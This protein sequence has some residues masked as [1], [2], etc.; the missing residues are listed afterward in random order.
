MSACNNLIA[1]QRLGV[2]K[3]NPSQA[4]DVI[5]NVLASS[6][7]SACNNLIAIQ[8]LG[9]VKTNPSEAVDIIGNV[10]ASSNI[11]ACN[12]LIAIQRL[13]VV[14]TNPGEA[15]DVIGNALVS[16]NVSAC[17]NLVAIQRLGVVKTNPG[18]AIDVIG[19]ALVSGNVSACNNLIAVQR[20]GVVK[21]NPSEAV[22]VIGNMLASSN[23]SACNNLIA[24]QR[25][26]VVKTNPGEAVDVIGNILTSS[27]ITAC[28]NLIAVRRL[29]VVKTNPSEALDIVGNMLGSSNI[30]ACNNI[31]AIQ[32]L[33]V[34]KTNPG[35]AVDVIGNV[36]TTGN[37]SACNNLI[38][39]QKLGVVKTN[40]SEAVDVIGNALVSGNVSACNN[41]VAIQR[42]G[43]VKTNPGEAVDVIG[44]AL[45][46]GNVSACNN[47]VA[48]QRLGVVKTNPGEAVDVI[49][50]ILASSNIT[51]CNNLVAIQ[52]LGVVKTNPGE[53]V[54]VIGNILA[55]SNITACNTLLAIQRLGV[56]KTNPGEAVDIIGNVLAS[57][58]ISACNN[59]IAVQRLGVVKT[60][61]SQAVDVIGNILASSNITACN[62]LIA[63]QKLGVVKTNP[64]E[65]IDVIGNALVS[66]NVSACNNLIAIQR[67]GVV[68]TNPGEAI[69]VI[70]N[71]LVSGN[72]SA[73]NNLI[74]I[75]RLGVVKT[76]PSEAVDI[77]G[78][79]LATGN[80]SACNNLIAIQ[81]LGV[82]TS[83]PTEALDVVGNIRASSNAYIMNNLGVRTSNPSVSL[84]VVGDAKM[85]N[86]LEVLGN[87]TVRGNTT[88][89]DSTTVNIAD[90]IIR[91]NNGQQYNMALQAGLEIYRGGGSNSNYYLVF[92]EATDYF[93]VG[94]QNGL[95]TL[96][97]R[98]DN[99][100]ANTIPIYNQQAAMYTACN[101][102]TYANGFLGVGTSNPSSDLH[103]AGVSPTIVLQNTQ[104]NGVTDL[105]FMGSNNVVLSEML[106]TTSSSNLNIINRIGGNTSIST[107]NNANAFVVNSNGRVGINTNAPSHALQIRG[108]LRVHADGDNPL[109]TLTPWL[110]ARA[111][112]DVTL[113]SFE[114]QA[115]NTLFRTGPVDG[116]ICLLPGSGF[117]GVARSN[118]TC[119]LDVFGTINATTYSNLQNQPYLSAMSNACFT[120]SNVAYLSSN[121]AYSVSN[122]AY[123]ASSNALNSLTIAVNASNAVYNASSIAA[124][125]ATA[126]AANY[127]SN[128]AFRTSN[129]AFPAS[130]AA[131]PA[132]N[133]A[134]PASNA[135]FPASN[136]AY[137]TSN[138]A[139]R[140]SNF[141]YGGG[142]WSKTGNDLHYNTGNVGI[143]TTT[144]AYALDVS[145]VIRN[146]NSIITRTVYN[147]GTFNF[148]TTVA[149]NNT[150]YFFTK[151]TD[152]CFSF[153]NQAGTQTPLYINSNANIGVGTKTPSS[154][155]AVQGTNGTG[156]MKLMID[157]G[158]PSDSWWM[159]FGH[160]GLSTDANDRARIGVNIL[161]GGAGRLYF[162]TG[163][164]GGQTERMRIDESGNVGI[165]TS[166]PTYKLDVRG[167]QLGFTCTNSNINQQLI[168]K[169]NH[170][171]AGMI[172][173]P[174]G[175][176][177][178]QTSIY[179][180]PA[181]GLITSVAA[182][183]F[184]QVSVDGLSY[185]ALRING[186]GTVGVGLFNP[187]NKLD[188]NGGCV[189]GTTYAG[190]NTAPTDGLLVAGNVG[191]G[192]TSPAYALD[193][194]GTIN[195][196]TYNNLQNQPYL[197]TM[198]NACFTGSN[199]AYL[200][201]NM[202]FSVSNVAYVASSN[203]TNSLEIAINASNAVYNASSIAAT[204]DTT[205]AAN[206]GSNTASRTS[207]VAYTTSNFV[208]AGGVWSKTGNT[209]F[210]N[211]GNIG[212]GTGSPSAL[213]T[214]QNRRAA[215]GA[216]LDNTPFIRVLKTGMSNYD[217]APIQF[218]RGTGEY[219]TATLQYVNGIGNEWSYL[220][221]GLDST[222]HGLLMAYNGNSNNAS[223]NINGRDFVNISTNNV[224]R[225]RFDSNG[226]VGIG[227]SN[228]SRP[229]HVLTPDSNLGNIMLSGAAYNNSNN[230]TSSMI[231]ALGTNL[232]DQ[233]QLW[234]MSS[235]YSAVNN[236]NLAARVLV[237]STMPVFDAVTTDGGTLRMIQIGNSAG[238]HM[239]GNVGVGTTSPSNLL[240]VAG[241]ASIGSYSNF[242]APTNG[243]IVSGNVGVG[244]TSPSN[245]LTVAGN[246]SVGSYSNVVAPTN[247]LIV[248][249][250]VGIGTSN[251]THSLD[252]RGTTR[253]L[254]SGGV[255][256]TVRDGLN[257]VISEFSREIA[258]NNSLLQVNFG[259]FVINS[260]NHIAFRP[261]NNV[262][263]GTSNP[264]YKLD[265]VGN[266]GVSNFIQF[267][268]IDAGKRIVLW[269]GGQ[270]AYNGIGKEAAATTYAIAATSDHHK[271]VAYS[272]STQNELMRIEG[273]GNVGIGKPSP[274]SRLDVQNSVNTNNNGIIRVTQ[275]AKSDGSTFAGIMFRTDND[276][277]SFQDRFKSGIFHMSSNGD[278]G[279][280][281]MYFCLN[282]TTGT[283]TAVVKNDAKMVLTAAGRL[284]VGTSNPSRQL[285]VV[286]PS[287]NLCLFVTDTNGNNQIAGIE[288]GIGNNVRSKIFS[289]TKSADRC[290]MTFVVQNGTNAPVTAMT[291]DE[292]GEVGIGTT[293]PSARLHISG[294]GTPITQNQLYISNTSA[295]TNAK[296]WGFGPNGNLFNGYL[297][298]D[299]FSTTNTSNFVQITRNGLSVT[300]VCFPLGTVGVGTTSPSTS[301]KLDVSG[302][303]RIGTG[304]EVS[305]LHLS[306]V[307]TANWK[308]ST[309]GSRL[310]FTNDNG[311][312]YNSKF[313]VQTTGNFGIG[314]TSPNFLL[315]VS[316]TA[317]FKFK[318]GAWY[319]SDDNKE[320]FYC[321][322]SSHTYLK[323]AG[324]IYFRTGDT[325]TE[326]MKMQSDGHIVA[327]SGL[328]GAA[329]YVGT[330][331][332]N[333]GMNQNTNELN[334][335]TDNAKGFSF[336][337]VDG[338]KTFMKILN[339]GNIGIGTTT[340]AYTLDVSGDI[341][342]SGDI[343]ALSD[344]RYKTNLQKITNVLDKLDNIN[345]YTYTRTDFET[346]NE[347]F[348]KRHVG[349]LAQE[350]REEFP[351]VTSLDA[352]GNLN[353]SYTS[354]VPILL[355]AIKEL[356]KELQDLKQARCQCGQPC[357]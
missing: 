342:A 260:T 15:V 234:M 181:G 356:R 62:N 251:P 175:N 214:V 294:S 177:A 167:D 89:V 318:T 281:D 330:A 262:G 142:V 238:V 18:E 223:T 233:T 45:V 110:M 16:G 246:V 103:I 178:L 336:T 263:I 164:G 47:L 322:S 171:R 160:A 126:D 169:N 331:N 239:P 90:N 218:G 58:N 183:T 29:G 248:S 288:F 127:G 115:N 253:M 125:Q 122:V 80:I 165:G 272:G 222:Q 279:I 149:T 221:L 143:G 249:G 19:N 130:N 1:V 345:A 326:R 168:I 128:T 329:L 70:G 241:N 305:T 220:T 254:A 278:F 145:G 313:C 78:N 39:V 335:F 7:I 102:L 297:L 232:N 75:Q 321:T 277:G 107:N 172:L 12:N 82:V 129:A 55:S 66:G 166:N 315:D 195:A 59:L 338:S 327:Y 36:L 76:N 324:D 317:N 117:V 120:G 332:L 56:V 252:V 54:D 22:D 116:S 17:N 8:R 147:D 43:V 174:S 276:L 14:K 74:A 109:G 204:Q 32:R 2:V 205:N 24:M 312:T 97:T 193:V 151:D 216:A 351:D 296:S 64:S 139:H 44:N 154:R 73:C 244:T 255:W 163:I 325:N 105:Q 357:Q 119:A 261:T 132:S 323:S 180:Q 114:R 289:T 236:T 93:K 328:Q 112:N 197:S 46:S 274:Q 341:Y 140:T 189:I 256:L 79:V 85:N 94:I 170:G 352:K 25:L 21:T 68:K 245:L 161:E 353:L 280:G 159:G 337:K 282:N 212:I 271:F 158:N 306:D 310:D 9:V 298:N 302:D 292:L 303:L 101:L 60:N 4:V 96:A 316:G 184:Y 226:N 333:H 311:G 5:G 34:V 77:I 91:I 83:V 250:N 267:P 38:A 30:T 343:I 269:D 86:N 290:D 270:Q 291:I 229:L 243:L 13:G 118:P 156:V 199:V 72:V 141:V 264:S 231:M 257:N 57:G 227:T 339:G 176:T 258:N 150:L 187:K 65:A 10:L 293:A 63:I 354:M 138:V 41:L 53:A 350:V 111:D 133:V 198:S 215:I 88:V 203:A 211:S 67:L 247:G 148:G 319:V 259:S 219:N 137:G 202:A 84:E 200:S 210:Y 52:R 28:N 135:A 131:F 346:L 144:P 179:T 3:T 71:A 11:S 334:F 265:V 33:G 31:I 308:I 95:Q 266:M 188:I 106:F 224:N 213:L 92:D 50:N 124:T 37:I 182:N 242:V 347:P 287:S 237:N 108:A 217:S 284:G 349:C 99:P 185:E 113:A 186:D 35:E 104:V 6:N 300:S 40:P 340:P 299:A 235:L 157:S 225:M 194:T 42:L 230:R 295:T 285:Q 273:D 304:T 20:L 275:L 191:I 268:N 155:L 98:V 162:T 153:N 146:N 283:T 49:G 228:P 355:Q 173:I 201:S 69:D 61:P 134:F 196:T 209:L 121:M 301:Y 208:Y 240:T 136:V 23:I 286:S 26:G 307:S 207:N 27:N 348:D 81:R 320:R 152:G 100:S 51:A 123:V 192:T 344:A 206:F 309:G 48:I 190:V 314:T 87:L